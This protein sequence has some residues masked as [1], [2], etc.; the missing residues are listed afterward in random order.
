MLLRSFPGVSSSLRRT[1]WVGIVP[2][3][4][5]FGLVAGLAWGE[6]VTVVDFTRD[7]ATLADVPFYTGGVSTLGLL[8]WSA[9]AAMCFLSYAVLRTGTASPLAQCIAFL[10]GLTLVLVLDDAY[11]LHEEVFPDY[12]G[13]SGTLLYGL[14]G[15]IVGILLLVYRSVLRRTPYE[16]LAFSL[17]ALALS[18]GTDV[19]MDWGYLGAGGGGYLVEDG[20]KLLGIVLWTSYVGHTC[21]T[22]LRKERHCEEQVGLGREDRIESPKGRT[23][24]QSI[25]PSEAL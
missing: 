5:L 12:F 22:A 3:L 20:S 4:G 18:L 14:Y 6:D 13:L 23:S 11:M 8:L 21:A 25:S 24:R 2:V 1:F 19:F 17:G 16:L 7:L 10:G 15:G 9:A